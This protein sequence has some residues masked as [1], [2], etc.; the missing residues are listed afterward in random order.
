MSRHL[1][2]ALCVT[3]CLVAPTSAL[4]DPTDDSLGFPGDGARIGG[5]DTWAKPRAAEPRSNKARKKG[6][7]GKRTYKNAG[8]AKA[9]KKRNKGAASSRK[10]DKKKKGSDRRR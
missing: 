8:D 4:A 9:S 6:D 2:F 10:M 1:I 5:S 3:T 7:A